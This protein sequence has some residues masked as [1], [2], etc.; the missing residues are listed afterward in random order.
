MPKVM[1][2]L[3]LFYELLGLYGFFWPLSECEGLKV[4]LLF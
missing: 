3:T 4:K 2:Y 1:T